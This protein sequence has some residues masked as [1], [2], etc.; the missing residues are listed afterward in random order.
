MKI[1]RRFFVA[2]W[3]STAAWLGAM[4]RGRTAFAAADAGVA[5]PRAGAGTVPGAP[6]SLLQLGREQYAKYLD[7]AQL[8]MLDAKLGE[9]EARGKRLH[10][11]N[12]SNGE[13]PAADFRPVR[14]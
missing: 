1:T 12:L 14:S 5:A 3:G 9:I 7:E 2:A 13:E 4:L 10:A 6:A 8:K 11:F